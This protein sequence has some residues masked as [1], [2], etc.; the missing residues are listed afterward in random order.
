[1]GG[2]ANRIL[3][4]QGERLQNH[5]WDVAVALGEPPDGVTLKRSCALISRLYSF[6]PILPALRNN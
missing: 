5:P 3:A 6:P 1:M 4:Q 2:K